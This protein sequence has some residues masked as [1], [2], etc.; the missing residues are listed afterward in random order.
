MQDAGLLVLA[1]RAQVARQVVGRF[2][3]GGV[4]VAEGAAVAGEGVVAEGAWRLERPLWSTK[5]IAASTIRSW[6]RLPGP[7]LLDRRTPQDRRRIR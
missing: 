5:S 6:D 7:T 3:G 4:V 1:Q 2:E